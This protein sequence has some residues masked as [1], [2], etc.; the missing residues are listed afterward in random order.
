MNVFRSTLLVGA[1]AVVPFVSSA[2]AFDTDRGRLAVGTVINIADYSIGTNHDAIVSL[3]AGDAT[4]SGE[5][6]LNG[7]GE[8]RY[9][10]LLDGAVRS[11]NLFCGDLDDDTAMITATFGADNFYRIAC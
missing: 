7:E 9:Y 2:Y 11:H 6:E 1:L 10:T 3:T 8:L 5:V 4:W